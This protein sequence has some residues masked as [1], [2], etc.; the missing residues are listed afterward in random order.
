MIGSAIKVQAVR[1]LAGIDRIRQ[2]WTSWQRHPNADVDFY[3]TVLNSRPEILRPH[4]FVLYRDGRP[5]AMLIG[6]IEEGRIEYKFGYKTFYRA[7]VRQLTL[8]YGGRLGNFSAENCGVLA[9][10]VMKCLRQGEADVAFLNHLRTDSPFYAAITQLPGF[11]SRDHFQAAVPHRSMKLPGRV[12]E[13]SRCIPGDT[14]REARR[15][16][17]LLSAD[18]SNRVELRCFREV[19]DLECML[20]D[21]EEIARKTYQ[22]GLGVGF[23]DGP[24]TRRRLS[25]E[26]EK[27]WLR[28]YILYVADKP[29]A[30]WLGSL[31]DG[32]FH[33]GDVGYD[34]SFRK[35]APGTLVLMKILED[36]CNNNVQEMDFGLGDAEWKQRFGNEQWLE[37]SVYVFAPRLKAVSLNLL[38]APLVLL[39]ELMKKVLE[40][41]GLLAKL[42]KA[43]RE[44]LR[45]RPNLDAASGRLSIRPENRSSE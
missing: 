28:A 24:E 6:R 14:R 9:H 32:T 35:Y 30:F 19:P 42:K 21:V 4:I 18:Y 29:C 16:A 26:A 11:L 20:P 13:L 41:R 37:T 43:W 34:P 45:P 8:I 31:H 10:E 36:L 1:S 38:R 17:R 15:R 12:E 25:L 22:R 7:P 5:D 3:L 2:P 40:H 44:N 33:S 23:L 39:E 27:G